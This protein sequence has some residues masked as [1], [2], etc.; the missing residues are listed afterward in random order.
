[1]IA[2]VPSYPLFR[3]I[4]LKDSTML[5]EAFQ[6]YPPHI[7]ECTFTNLYVWRKSNKV[8]L[9][10]FGDVLLIKRK[11]HASDKFFLFPPIGSNNVVDV[12]EEIIT[13]GQS[14]KLP[15]F[16]GLNRIQAESLE[17]KGFMVTEMRDNWD[18][19][20]LTND[21]I[22]LPGERYYT[23]RKNIKKC[24]SEYKLE[25]ESL[26]QEIID[27]CLQLQTKWCNLKN[28]D[29]I[30]GLEEENRAI[31]ETFDHFS[32]LNIFGGAILDNGVVES[33]T[34]GEK[35]NAETA[36]IHFE[37]ANPKIPGLYQ[38]INQWFAQTTLQDYA[39]VNREQDLG[40][41]GLRRAKMSYNP[42][43][44]IEKFLV[45]S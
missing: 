37:K 36:V 6:A 41:P 26:T 32:D 19:I 13:R 29:S 44:F 16:Y 14:E 35:L 10:Q 15:P 31:K 40:I 42:A 4:D 43:F 24:L 39:Y 11:N 23:K 20:Y 28:C 27:Q 2:L 38:V 18:Y 21:L 9:T 7:S 8:Y 5:N 1:M 22:N 45:R 33:F 34:I 25:Y 12:I 3:E 17:T 30:P